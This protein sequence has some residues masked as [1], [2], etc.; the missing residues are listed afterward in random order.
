MTSTTA[1]WRDANMPYVESRRACDSRACYKP[2]SHPTYSIGAVDAGQSCFTGAGQEAVI[3]DAGTVVFVP[4]GM[5]HACNPQEGQAWSYQMLH[6]DAV[7]VNTLRHEARCAALPGNAAHQVMV[8]REP[9]V[10]ARFCQL[11]ALLFSDAHCHLKEAE[12]VA[13][14]GDISG[15]GLVPA[16][17]S[18]AADLLDGLSVVVAYLGTHD[19]GM[20]SLT[21][22]AQLA[23]MSRYQLIRA[24]RAA[25]GMTPHAYQL[26]LRVNQA[27]SRLRAGSSM[28]DLAYHLGFADQSHFQRVFKA[29]A[30]VTPGCYK[31]V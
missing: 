16:G 19:I 5:V 26:N 6:L 4:P 23:G 11:N 7:W 30:G 31:S 22:L 9:A 25:T 28:A 1:F 15:D 2:H 14:I 8:S 29:Y 18:Q 24:F 13:F 27:R 17:Q 10:Y 12:L 20:A 21:V 3:I